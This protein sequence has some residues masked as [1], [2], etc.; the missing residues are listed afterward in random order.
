MAP[1]QGAHGKQHGEDAVKGELHNDVFPVLVGF[2]NL[3]RSQHAHPDE[4]CSMRENVRRK[5]AD[6]T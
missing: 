1:V 4:T 3:F 5:A 2:H 6:R